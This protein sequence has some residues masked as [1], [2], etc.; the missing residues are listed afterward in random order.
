MLEHGIFF[1]KFF[2]FFILCQQHD[3]QIKY[4][5]ILINITH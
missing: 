4:I 1:V 5:K 3:N 2:I